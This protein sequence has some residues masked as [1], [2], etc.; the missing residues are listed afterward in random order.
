[1]YGKQRLQQ[2]VFDECAIH[3]APITY[4]IETGKL[5]SLKFIRCHLDA[6]LVPLL[7][8]TQSDGSALFSLGLVDCGLSKEEVADLVNVLRWGGSVQ[9]LDLSANPNA[10][11]G[12]AIELLGFTQSNLED[13]WWFR[14]NDTQRDL[15]LWELRK[16][17]SEHGRSLG[18]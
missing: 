13:V 6:T 14:N 11:A 17:K 4:L 8:S 7:K 12:A 16:I 1:M 15:A 5:G 10:S 3:L 2:L 18:S 9:Y